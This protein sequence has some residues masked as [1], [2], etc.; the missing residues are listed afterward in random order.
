MSTFLA[1]AA[2]ASNAALMLMT[3]DPIDAQKA[4]AWGLV[5]EVVSGDMLLSRAQEIAATIATRPPI[6]VETAKA[7][8]RAAYNLSQ[9]QSIAYER[10]LQ[11]VTFATEDAA[12]GRRAF[13]ERR[14]PK[15]YRR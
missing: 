5:T 10:D 15:F 3:G 6:A 7:N 1:H 8:L 9:D 14:Q 2:G 13:A 4:L 12:E 11:T